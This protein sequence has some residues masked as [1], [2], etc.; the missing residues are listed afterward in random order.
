MHGN[1]PYTKV[2]EVCREMMIEITALRAR[3]TQLEEEKRNLDQ[4]LNL[5]HRQHYDSLVHHLFSTCIHLKSRLDKYHVNMEQDVRRLVSSARTEAAERIIRLKNKLSSTKENEKFSQTLDEKEALEDLHAENSKLAGLFSKLRAFNH[6]RLVTGRGKLQKDLLQ[7]KQN[8]VSCKTEALKMKMIS[9]E[10][11]I[12]LKQELDAVQHELFQRKNHYEHIKR[13]IAQ[14]T[15]KLQDVEHR[16]VRDAQSLQELENLR[17]QSLGQLQEDV[18]DRDDQVRALSA[19]LEKN[20]RE[21]ELLQQRNHQQIKHVRGQLHQERSLK[22][23]ALQHVDKL[24]SQIHS[25]ETALS[26]STVSSGR[27][28]SS[29]KLHLRN[30]SAGLLRSNSI[31]PFLSSSF[32]NRDYTTE[33]L[34][35]DAG[36]RE[37]WTP[38]ERPKTNTSRLHLDISEALLPSLPDPISSSNHTSYQ[39][40]RFGHK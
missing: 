2:A 23:E 37:S 15:Q 24:Q 27:Q 34:C 13:Q 39:N 10:K 29:R 17:M 22:R 6:W 36:Y 19:Q 3:I 16:S 9:E 1:D 21:T 7:W 32:I 33:D 35:T 30:A 14:Q 5:K 11:V 12:V 38:L 20:T 26:K 25:F 18:V 8:E 4:H 28:S 40:F 31:T